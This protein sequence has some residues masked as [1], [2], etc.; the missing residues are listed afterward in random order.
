MRRIESRRRDQILHDR[1][2]RVRGGKCRHQRQLAHQQSKA[3]TTAL[4]RIE[5]KCLL[6]G[7]RNGRICQVARSNDGKLEFVVAH[8]VVLAH[9]LQVAEKGAGVGQ[10]GVGGSPI[11]PARQPQV[12][13][14]V[15]VVLRRVFPDSLATQCFLVTHVTRGA[16][17][18]QRA[19][20]DE[21][22][23]GIR[24]H[25]LHH[26]RRHHH[27]AAEIR[28]VIRQ[29]GHQLLSGAE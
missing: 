5:K 22:G 15:R 28:R 10:C 2:P 20:D 23:H 16:K 4:R 13:S 6:A 26:E 11:P 1:L 27:V 12:F 3:G 14:D 19:A 21:L 18:P 24:P 29:A 25:R 7:G 17:L 9:F 8:M